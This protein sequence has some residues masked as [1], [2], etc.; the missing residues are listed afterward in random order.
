MR[1]LVEALGQQVLFNKEICS[2][3]SQGLCIKDLKWDLDHPELP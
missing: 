1:D 3:A 2:M